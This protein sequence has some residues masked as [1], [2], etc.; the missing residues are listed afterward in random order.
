MYKAQVAENLIVYC[1]GSYCALNWSMPKRVCLQ[2]EPVRR[3]SVLPA[4]G[5]LRSVA[6]LAFQSREL[7]SERS[8]SRSLKLVGAWPR[9]LLKS[10]LK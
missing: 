7:R 4:P 10:R 6:D 8:R 3:Q 1:S 2:L 9:S 5:T